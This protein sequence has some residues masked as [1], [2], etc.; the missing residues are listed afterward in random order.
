MYLILQRSDLIH[1]HGDWSYRVILIGLAW[2]GGRLLL[3]GN[4]VTGIQHPLTTCCGADVR[5]KQFSQGGILEWE[6][7]PAPKH[8]L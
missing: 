5:T 1:A 2:S 7:T 8:G 6:G 3:L 4:V